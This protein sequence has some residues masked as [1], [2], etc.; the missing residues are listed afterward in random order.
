MKKH[1]WS[2]FLT[3]MLLA[4][5]WGSAAL[6]DAAQPDYAWYGSGSA[7]TYYLSDADDLLGF[8]HIVNGT[9]PSIAKDTFAQKTVCLT[10]DVDLTGIV[11]TPIGSS[12]YDHAAADADTRKFE[13]AFDGQ[14]HTIKGLSSAGYVPANG[15]AGPS[16]EYAFGLFGYAYGANIRNVKLKDVNISGCDVTLAD[17][18]TVAGSGV[19][20]LVGYYVPKHNTPSVIENCHLLSGTVKASNNMGGLMGFMQVHGEDNLIDV[21]IRGCT[22]K[23][24]VT[25]EARE[26]GGILGLLQQ[27]DI[28]NTGSVHFENCQNSGNITVKDGGSCSVAGG[29]LGQEN[30]YGSYGTMI[31][32]FDTCEN[33][34]TIKATGCSGAEIHASGIGT[35]YYSAGAWLVAMNCKNTGDIII[36]TPGG[37]YFYGGIFAYTPYMTLD[38]CTNTGAVTINGSSQPPLMASRAYSRLYL[39]KVSSSAITDSPPTFVLND[40]VTLRPR[41]Y[42]S[43][44]DTL[45]TPD[46][47]RYGYTFKGWFTDEALTTPAQTF[48]GGNTYYAKWTPNDY[49]VK[50]DANGGS[51]QPMAPKGFTFD[52]ADQALPV[53]TY[54]R[55]HYTY[56]GWNTQPD[57]SGN[58]FADKLA[59]PNVTGE[60][61]I[62]L[63]AQWKGHEYAIAYEGMAGAVQGENHP[64]VHTYGT[65]SPISNPT[66][67]GYTFKGWV[68][69]GS[70][71]PQKDLTLGASA[72]TAKITLRAEWEPLPGAVPPATGDSS[73]LLLWG[74]LLMMGLAGAMAAAPKGMG[75][76]SK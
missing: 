58:A 8:A 60:G 33:S 3:L 27:M 32:S 50:F 34:G 37:P 53:N 65:P 63:Y 54:T 17:G 73:N 59:K 10:D 71:N 11:W 52:R 26:A 16:D 18:R 19:A 51:G 43:S 64:A 57:G 28:S 69:N 66:K 5:L 44:S 48:V 25:S 21:T 22:N 15:D 41:I 13:G 46:P 40:G 68:V 4:G 20:A 1:L 70:G 2:L 62:T 42:N 12:M 75:K 31:I 7:K 30:T 72:Y 47:T 74:L 38:R 35:E 56:T 14:N 61:T 45:T 55:S 49:T 9:A 76:G 23:A 24:A 39:N 29:I 36:E 6:A 67:N